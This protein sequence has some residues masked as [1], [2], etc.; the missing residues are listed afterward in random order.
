MPI[1]WFSKLLMGSVLMRLC[2]DSHSMV[3]Q[4]K[5]NRVRDVNIG[6]H[7]HPRFQ[8]SS[9]NY[10]PSNPRIVIVAPVYSKC[11]KQAQVWYAKE[12]RED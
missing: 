10:G 7:L 2:S 9:R 1:L 4:R 5:H 12:E 6:S 11:V 3:H 8:Q